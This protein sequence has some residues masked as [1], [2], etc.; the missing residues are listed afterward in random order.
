M[1]DKARGKLEKRRF[2]EGIDRIRRAMEDFEK[3]VEPSA[4]KAEVYTAGHSELEQALA[5]LAEADKAQTESLNGQ[6]K[7][8]KQQ[9]KKLHEDLGK[10]EERNKKMDELAQK[11]ASHKALLEQ[12]PDIEQ[13]EMLAE[14]VERALH[15]VRPKEILYQKAEKNHHD[16]AQEIELLTHQLASLEEE[17][18]S[19]KNA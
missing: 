17:R 9:E 5:E 14:R 16:T 15:K 13:L 11:E 3:P 19:Q 8:Y 4:E 1:L 7:N 6:L 12:K 2:E 18:T 10:A